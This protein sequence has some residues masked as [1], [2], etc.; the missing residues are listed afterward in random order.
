MNNKFKFQN[1]R[2]ILS[3]FTI[4]FFLFICSCL[5]EREVRETKYDNG[6]TKEKYQV[7]RTRKGDRWD[8]LYQ[9]WYENGQLNAQGN[10]K[11]RPP[12]DTSKSVT[13]IPLSGREGLW[14]FWF[15][16]GQKQEEYNFK[17]GKRDGVRTCWYDNGQKEQENHYKNDVYDG[18]STYW[19]ANGQLYAQGNFKHRTF[20]DTT[21]DSAGI[22]LDKRDGLWSFWYKNGQKNEEGNYKNGNLDGIRTCWNENGQ[23]EQE[24]NYKNGQISDNGM[25]LFELIITNLGLFI[26]ILIFIL[27]FIYFIPTFIAFSR[28]HDSKGWLLFLNIFLGWTVIGWIY[29]LFWASFGKTKQKKLNA[30]CKGF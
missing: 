27:I 3:F 4:S 21:K 20:N 9:R 11:N 28:K 14:S 2:I 29:S 13:G 16:N 8:G 23:K 7:L 15:D 19:Y 18:I 17:N 10:F 24:C 26:Y 5:S 25:N 1:T 22:P 30:V 6:K 12:N